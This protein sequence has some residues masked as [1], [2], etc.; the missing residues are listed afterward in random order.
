MR[1]GGKLNK[2][3]SGN[4]VMARF[5]L[6][7]DESEAD[8]KG[9]DVIVIKKLDGAGLTFEYVKNIEMGAI[10]EFNIASPIDKNWIHCEG[11]I[12][13]LDENNVRK[14]QSRPSFRISANFTNLNQEK[15]DAIE[16]LAKEYY[17]QEI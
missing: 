10:V 5:R 16:R 3:N 11:V 1:E 12:C 13:R 8:N 14:S 7:D 17:S 4:P 6:C 9:W 15:S 2:S